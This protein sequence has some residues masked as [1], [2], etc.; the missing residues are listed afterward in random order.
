MD[1]GSLN[2][3]DVDDED[4]MDDGVNGSARKPRNEEPSRDP[5]DYAGVGIKKAAAGVRKAIQ[6]KKS[7]ECGDDN[8]KRSAEYVYNRANFVGK[9]IPTGCEPK[10]VVRVPIHVEE[11]G[12]KHDIRH[13]F[14]MVKKVQEILQSVEPKDFLKGERSG[15]IYKFIHKISEKVDEELS[16]KHNNEDELPSV[17]DPQILDFIEDQDLRFKVGTF[18]R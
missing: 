5:T 17:D 16:K 4:D 3:D 18:H 13:F 7:G 14:G 15:K 1:E 8:R 11:E 9:N 6:E 10:P 12:V 2:Q